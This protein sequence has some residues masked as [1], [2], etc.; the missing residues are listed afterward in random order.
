[1]QIQTDTQMNFSD[2]AVSKRKIDMTFFDNIN[3]IVD[4]NKLELIIKKYYNKGMS[5]DGRPAYEGILLFKI[6]LLQTWFKLSDQA[7]EERINDSIKFT[8]FLGQSLED[9]VPDH[10]V[11]SR[12]RKEM[13]EKNAMKKVLG[14]LNRQLVKHNIIVKTG[15]LVDASLS[16]SPYTPAQPTTFEMA[17]DR[18]EEERTEEQTEKEGEYH[19]K[20]TRLENNG[21]DQQA[22]WLKKG[23]KSY[24]GYKKHTATN[25]DGMVLGIETTPANESDTKHFIPL[26]TKLKIKK[27]TR[28]KTDKGYSSKSNKEF[29]KENKLKN[30]IQYKGVRGKEITARE[31]QFNKMV[32]KTRYAVERTFGSIKKWFNGGVAK[33]K[34]L[35]KMDYQ[36]HLEAMAYNLYRSPGLVRAHADK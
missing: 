19:K 17:T 15:V 6:T 25:D 32:S 28:V 16:V 20:L 1:M 26:L 13:S 2:F 30:G 33:Y 27:G 5:A 12:F 18:I 34:G 10:S 7:V 22:R 36:H 35:Q 3:K 31:K 21:T 23:K 14:E 11:I 29:L 4:W 8:R 24:Y 9:S